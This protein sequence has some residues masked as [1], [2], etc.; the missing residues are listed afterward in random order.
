MKYL[1]LILLLLTSC[2]FG[3]MEKRG[4]VLYERAQF[5][6]LAPAVGKTLPDLTLRDL[7]G[8]KVSLASLRKKPLV[9]IGG[10][11]T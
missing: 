10:A 9:I 3:Q 8:K 6:K 4:R 7:S 5:R 2:A 11:Y 1:T